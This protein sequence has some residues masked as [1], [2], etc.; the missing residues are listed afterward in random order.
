MFSIFTINQSVFTTNPTYKLEREL[1]YSK[2]NEI[3]MNVAY[4]LYVDFI[5]IEV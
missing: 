4:S 5:K 2:A 1:L 3:L